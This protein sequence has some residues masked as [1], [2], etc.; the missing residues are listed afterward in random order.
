MVVARFLCT[1]M[2][3]KITLNIQLTIGQV[4]NCRLTGKLKTKV[5]NIMIGNVW[6]VN[7][8]TRL[9]SCSKHFCPFS[10]RIL[11]TP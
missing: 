5:Q 2:H 1:I 11:L 10:I 3:G 7:L 8:L 9:E 4:A 6:N